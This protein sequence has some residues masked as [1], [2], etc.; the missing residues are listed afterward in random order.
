MVTQIPISRN[1]RQLATEEFDYN[2]LVA[3]VDAGT[4]GAAPTGGRTNGAIAI[5]A[6]LTQHRQDLTPPGQSL[7]QLAEMLV[8]LLLDPWIETDI[9]GQLG[10]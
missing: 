3:K 8:D 4:I 2:N 10:D 6:A 5:R 1:H 7:G 9:R